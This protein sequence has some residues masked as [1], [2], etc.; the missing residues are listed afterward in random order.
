MRW[1]PTKSPDIIDCELCLAR[2][3]S[4]DLLNISGTSSMVWLSNG[5]GDENITTTA[6]NPPLVDVPFCK[7]ILLEQ[8]NVTR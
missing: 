3:D 1:I 5:S 2:M 8:I 6:V 4:S 7:Q